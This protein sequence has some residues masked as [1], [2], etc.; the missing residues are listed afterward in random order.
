MYFTKF[1]LFKFIYNYVE[2]LKYLNIYILFKYLIR[3]NKALRRCKNIKGN[4]ITTFLL[5]VP[6][7]RSIKYLL[8]GL[9]NTTPEKSS[10]NMDVDIITNVL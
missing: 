6:F 9:V 7:D 2:N 1:C 8:N 10:I 4:K 3:S 5:K